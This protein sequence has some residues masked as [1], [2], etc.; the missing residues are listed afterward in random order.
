MEGFDD[1]NGPDDDGGDEDTGAKKGAERQTGF[2][3]IAIQRGDRA[4]Y[5]RRAVTECHKRDADQ[6]L[7]ETMLY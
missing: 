7:Y 6:I 3:S 2:R 4:E 1:G 5:I